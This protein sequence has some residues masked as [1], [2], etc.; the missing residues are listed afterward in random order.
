M[1]KFYDAIPDDLIQWMGEQHIFFVASAPLAADGHVNLSPKGRDCLRVYS[2][3]RVAYLDMTGSGNETSAHIRENG[4]VTLMFCG[5]M[6]QSQSQE[7]SHS[8]QVL[9]HSR[10]L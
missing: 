6:C 10:L 9:S 2:P 5:Q 4:R 1:A 8:I 7:N 3:N